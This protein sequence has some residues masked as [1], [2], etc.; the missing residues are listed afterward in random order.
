MTSPLTG[1][2]I[3]IT[4]D[5]RAGEQAELLKRRGATVIHGPMIET[6]ALADTPEL[7][8]ACESLL[9]NPPDVMIATTG[10]GIRSWMEAAD[11]LG[12]GNSLRRVLGHVEVLARSPKA[13]GALLT[14]GLPLH[15]Q[16]TGEQAQDVI[17]YLAERNLA[18]LRIAVQRDGADEPVMAE[19][20][21]KRGA[22]VVDIPV[23]VFGN[24]RVMRE[25]RIA[26]RHCEVRELHPL[27]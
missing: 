13:A 7:R 26:L 10:V 21:A 6:L 19:T 23:E 5:R 3:G 11:G 9:A 18:G 24:L 14:A 27:A 16:A 8:L 22:E 25:I 12:L 2:T 20:L 1:F 4:G 15:W 17:D